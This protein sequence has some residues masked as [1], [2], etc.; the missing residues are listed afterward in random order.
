M[1]EK[2]VKSLSPYWQ[3]LATAAD[4]ILQRRIEK[5]QA[6]TVNPDYCLL[7]GDKARMTRQQWDIEG[8]QE[9]QKDVRKGGIVGKLTAFETVLGE[10]PCL[11][12]G[13]N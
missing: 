11:I 8:M 4:E 1:S 13:K 5:L 7:P 12:F 3:K 2:P 6:K 9:M 10:K